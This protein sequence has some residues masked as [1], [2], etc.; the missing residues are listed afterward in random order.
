MTHIE[1]PV[2]DEGRRGRRSGGGAEARRA[3]RSGGH[4]T[5]LS[6]IQR[7]IPLYE[8]LSEEEL[9]TIENNAETVLQ[10]IGID[11]RD[12]PEALMMWKNAGCDVRG[13]RVR[14]P[15]GLVRQLSS[16]RATR[17]GMWKLAAT[18]RCLRPFMAPPSCATMMAGAAMP[19]LRIS[20]IS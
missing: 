3:A 9:V 10:E 4:Q 5:Q 1:S 15:K 14:F 18:T 17:R 7:K 12:D 8:V 19:R 11:F 6:Y 13:E 16:M 2:A 20:A